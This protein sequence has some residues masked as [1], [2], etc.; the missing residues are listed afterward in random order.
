[1]K[2]TPLPQARTKET[3][4]R[5]RAQF[6]IDTRNNN[7]LFLEGPRNGNGA[8]RFWQGNS[9]AGNMVNQI[10]RQRQDVA[11][12]M[13]DMPTRPSSPKTVVLEQSILT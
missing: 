11:P 13:N 12:A 9:E 6:L 8:M 5:L 1:M 4:I 3:P 2:N 10:E 7:F